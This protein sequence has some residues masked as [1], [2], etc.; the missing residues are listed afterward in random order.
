MNLP[1]LYAPVNITFSTLR[2]LVGMNLGVIF[3]NDENVTRLCRRVLCVGGWKWQVVNYSNIIEYDYNIEVDKE[4]LDIYGS[5]LEYNE[6]L[7]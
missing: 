6:E 3:D 1:K 5:D 7:E 2:P 4:V